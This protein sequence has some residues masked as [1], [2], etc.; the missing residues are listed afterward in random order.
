MTAGAKAHRLRSYSAKWPPMP[1]FN[2]WQDQ[3]SQANVPVALMVNLLNYAGV[4]GL[5]HD[6]VLRQAQDEVYWGRAAVRAKTKPARASPGGFFLECSERKALAFSIMLDPGC[7]QSGK[8]VLVDGSLPV[9]ELVNAE[10]VAGAGLFKRQE[11]AA[12]GSNDFRFAA[13][14]PPPGIFWR[15]IC[16]R[17][18]TSV[19]TDYVLNARAHLY[20]HFTLYST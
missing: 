9:E 12:H 14:D 5:C 17:E 11:P 8:P 18:R 1:D 6:L 15:K 7:A 4:P 10:C 20:G 2:K 16:D 3:A 19:R 13:N